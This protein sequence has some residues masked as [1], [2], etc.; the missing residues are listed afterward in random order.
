M[1]NN[2]LYYNINSMSRNEL[3]RTAKNLATDLG[4]N[5]QPLSQAYRRSTTAYWQTEIRNY[6]RNIRNRNN[7]Y[8]RALRISRENRE[9][10]ARVAIQQGTDYAYW[11][12]EVRRLQMRARRNP[13]GIQAVQQARARVAPILQE[14]IQRPIRRQ[15][16]QVRARRQAVDAELRQVTA[17]RN[18]RAL[19]R[20]FRT[21]TRALRNRSRIVDYIHTIDEEL[22]LWID[23][24]HYEQIRSM[25]SQLVNIHTAS[26]T[27]NKARITLNY[28]IEG[29]PRV[30]SIP[31]INNIINVNLLVQEFMVRVIRDLINNYAD[32]I[33]TKITI[34][35][36]IPN[37]ELMGSS[38]RSIAQANSTW[39]MVSPKSIYNCLY[40]AIA[41]ARNYTSNIK[42]LEMSKEGQDARCQSGL[43][44]KQRIK[45][46]YDI[47]D[48][49]ADNQS[50]QATADYTQY[51]IKLYNNLWKNVSPKVWLCKENG[52]NVWRYANEAKNKVIKKGKEITDHMFRPLVQLKRY[53]G[54][55]KEYEIQRIN[56]H[57]V[58]LIR[59]N[60]L[61]KIHPDKD[62][63]P[64]KYSKKQMER[65]C[66]PKPSRSAKKIF[67]DDEKDDTGTDTNMEI[68]NFQWTNLPEIRQK[69]YIMRAL[70]ELKRYNQELSK[71][72]IAQPYLSMTQETEEKLKMCKMIKPKPDFGSYNWKIATWDLETSMDKNNKHI[73]YACGLAWNNYQY[74]EPRTKKE[75][76]FVKAT[77]HLQ[78]RKDYEDMLYITTKQDSKGYSGYTYGEIVKKDRSFAV[79]HCGQNTQ[80]TKIFKH[81]CKPK[82][83]GS[84]KVVKQFWGKNCLPDFTKYLAD[85]KETFNGYTLYAHNGGKYDLPLAIDKAFLDTDY[86]TIEGK[87]CCE[88]NNAWIGFTL[89]GKDDNKFKIKF[90][91]SFRLLPMSLDK[92]TKELKVEHQKLPETINHNHITLI[93]YNDTN[94]ID[95]IKKYL[96]HDVLG[97]L[98][99]VEIFGRGV[100]KDLGIDITACYTGASLSKKN[101]FKNYYDGLRY[102]VYTLTQEYDKFVRDGY[103]GGRVE[104]F[105]IGEIA[106]S[107][108]YDFTSLYPDVGRNYLPYGEPINYIIKAPTAENH[109]SVETLNEI[110]QRNKDNDKWYVNEGDD[111]G[112]LPT[113]FFG[114]GKILVKT[115]DTKLIPKHAFLKGSRLVFPVFENWTEISLFSEE[116]D[117][118]QYDYKFLQLVKFKK[119]KFKKKFFD[120]GF[121]N[122][123]KCKADGDLAMAQ[124][125]KIII[126]SGYGFWGLRT[127]GRDGVIICEKDSNEYMEYLNTDKLLGIREYKDYT[128]CRVLKDLDIKD[129]N[130]AVASAISSY[131]RVKLHTL[132]NDIRK[133]GGNIYYCDTDSVICS[134]NINEHPELKQKHQ[135]DGDGSE[136][137]SLKNECDEKVDGLLKKLFP[138][139]CING[140]DTNKPKRKQIFDELVANENGNLS[141]DE[142][143]IT[144]CKQYALKKTIVVEGKEHVLE[145]VK[146]KGYSQRDTESDT[147]S[148]SDLMKKEIPTA[149][150]TV[151]KLKYDDMAK[152]NL[153]VKI[154]QEQTQ[155]RCPKSNYVSETQAFNINS[156][157]INKSFRRTYT[158]G[159]IFANGWV[160]PLRF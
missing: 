127:K 11:Q 107:Y 159:Q 70:I 108:Y 68:L 129:F 78:F 18:A 103:F 143:I 76:E 150:K 42:L 65:M 48:N 60:H 89:R 1:E 6:Q 149:S 82:I 112:K 95:A 41:I 12:R 43:L 9:P 114:W 8:N 10:L 92:L 63:I 24:D 140:V 126:N 57:C 157:K 115:K 133:V 38:V 14:V 28:L 122:K 155:F 4:Y 91:D 136:L 56:N 80:H 16:A 30:V 49:Y 47:L 34:S 90:R 104:V 97:L 64:K 20:R 77:Y 29:S 62:I 39:Y 158:K 93:N 120:D 23:N 17:I 137:G 128:I 26:I 130:V 119:A 118:D 121:M 79:W 98:E 69:A 153:G 25:V 151:N 109:L 147:Y 134:I 13:L 116:L 74:G 110:N 46:R 37:D 105:K 55:I 15:Q 156:K 102:P 36:F 19:A 3:Y 52:I 113:D 101:F 131:A 81:L 160:M 75:H 45:T 35:V 51:P 145:I 2:S 144:G 84:K 31:Y 85:N 71:F 87:N 132:L 7:T 142:G 125:Y 67:C 100:F 44:L 123:A 124:A 53:K 106:K 72:R 5:L 73:A 59:K 61:L 50:I 148:H 21:T 40:Q 27:G 154:S 22:A 83:I 32:M 141:F 146:L 139:V 138:T 135:W 54:I 66:I 86:F 58:A 94:K 33:I 117:Y 152:M 88:L 111:C 99:V 96:D